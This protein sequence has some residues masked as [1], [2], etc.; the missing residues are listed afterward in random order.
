VGDVVDMDDTLLVSI[1]K[2]MLDAVA[3]SVLA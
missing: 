2:T 3:L 1:R